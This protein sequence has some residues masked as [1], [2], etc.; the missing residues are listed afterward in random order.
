[1]D[2][3]VHS[4]AGVWSGRHLG[5]LAG[6]L[7][8]S[9][10]GACARGEG[11]DPSAEAPLT[12]DPKAS[13]DP[14]DPST[15]P[16]GKDSAPEKATGTPSEGCSKGK[17]G[18]QRGLSINVRG[19]QRAYDL[20]VPSSYDAKKSY[21]LVFAFHGGGGDAQSA[22]E[23]FRFS[24]IAG[25]DAI[26]VYPSAHD[27]NWDL[28]SP[29]DDNEDVAFFDAVVASLEASHCVDKTRIFATGYSN[30]GYFS[31]QLG[32]R[33]G[34]VLRAIASHAGGGPYGGDDGYDDSG[35]LKCNGKPVAA[36]I[37]HSEDDDTVSVED[38]ESSVAHWR[39]ANSCN[40]RTSQAAPDPCVS[41]DG[42]KNPVVWCG[43]SG[44]GHDFWSEGAAATFRF[45]AS[46]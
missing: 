39:W 7:A 15:A 31:N 24:R 11:E 14:T 4:C 42:C 44:I 1:M 36:M 32:C 17:P 18:E 20:S 6:I 37:F 26:F 28:D 3:I 45:F 2:G 13:A 34:N 23:T 25:N 10:L 22:R 46:F 43:I 19:S 35:H 40:A 29:A 8:L 9:V 12:Q 27:G 30:G 5:R 21:P 41:F 33:R 16:R 38:G